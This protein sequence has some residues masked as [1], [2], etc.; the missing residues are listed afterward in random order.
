MNNF[1]KEDIKFLIQEFNENN[2]ESLEYQNEGVTLK[3]SKKKAQE[4]QSAIKEIF[5][6]ISQANPKEIEIVKSEVKEVIFDY[7]NSPIVGRVYLTPKPGE[8][9]FIKV[10][11]KIEVGQV[12]CIIEAMKVMN[13]VKSDKAGTVRKILVQSN[14]PVEFDQRLIELE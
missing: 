6:E 9:E 3:L 13:Q 8:P 5:Q 11:D 7:I 4:S 14:Q 12:I 2:L 1:N 10:G